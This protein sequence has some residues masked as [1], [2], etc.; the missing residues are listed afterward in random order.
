MVGGPP[1]SNFVVLQFRAMR[2]LS[3]WL[4][5]IWILLD[6]WN[7]FFSFAVRGVRRKCLVYT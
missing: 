4:G 6:S 7:I 1:G 2:R 5:R 3:I